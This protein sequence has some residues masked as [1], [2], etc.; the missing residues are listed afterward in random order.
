M[1][2]KIAAIAVA[3]DEAVY[4]PEFIA[5]H[6]YFG[7]SEIII[8]INRTSD[9]SVEILNKIGRQY[10][11]RHEQLDWLDQGRITK[12][13][14]LQTQGY[15]YLTKKLSDDITD[16]VF[17]DIDEL[18]FSR[19]FR[20]GLDQ[21]ASSH[22]FDIMSFNWINQYGDECPFSRP[23]TALRGTPN[24]HRKSMIRKDVINCIDVFRAHVPL[25]KRSYISS[26]RHIDANGQ[27]KDGFKHMS[28]ARDALAAPYYVL[29]R[30]IRSEIEY[31]CHL[32]QGMVGT[33]GRLKDNRNG[34][35]SNDAQDTIDNVS[36]PQNY[37]HF[38]TAFERDCGISDLL[39][40][41]R[42]R[43]HNKATS[44]LD[45]ADEQLVVDLRTYKKV[46]KGTSHFVQLYRRLLNVSD[47]VVL[48]RS[49]K[50]IGSVDFSL[51]ALLMNKAN[52]LR[53]H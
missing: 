38:L 6:L 34:Y 25:P 14:K 37:F 23:F 30:F 15:A 39:E 8:G 2:R 53:T 19:D 46:L 9:N 26:L 52:E 29:H 12:N 44:I 33:S 43:L 48:D 20:T 45:V 17:L 31:V 1:K 10:N 18:W 5:H 47:P 49:A 35:F 11:I 50:E 36:V 27:K 24:V 42:S 21:V 7:I 51:S 16:I 22:E 32:M 40:Q 28:N 4:L 41:G 13:Y 3:K